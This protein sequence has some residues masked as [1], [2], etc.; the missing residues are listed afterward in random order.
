MIR[1][2]SHLNVIETWEYDQPGS[3][4]QLIALSR[5]CKFGNMSTLTPVQTGLLD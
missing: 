2:E 4:S 1:K 3:R 5:F